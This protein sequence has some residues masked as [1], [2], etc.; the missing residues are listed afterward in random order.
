MN[1]GASVQAMIWSVPPGP[2]EGSFFLWTAL[3]SASTKPGINTM[4][5]KG[6]DGLMDKAFAA[7]TAAERKELY[8]QI[9]KKVV[10]DLPIL[11]VYFERAVLA[12]RKEV[13]MGP[14]VNG[15]TLLPSLWPWV[16]IEVFDKRGD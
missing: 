12:V 4:L 11:P 3:D 9:Q 13:D 5:Y 10:E 15:Q 7:K 2:P 16:N 6:V 8:G 14:T 1:D